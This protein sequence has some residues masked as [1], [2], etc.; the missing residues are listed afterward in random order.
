MNDINTTITELKKIVEDFIDERDWS[1]FHNPKNL[2]MALAIEAGELMDIFKWNST[3]E[4]DDMMS[5]KNTKQD[6]TDELADIMIYALAFSNR[7]NINISSAIEEK[8]IKNRKKYPTEK[9]K[10]HF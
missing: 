2:S 5:E 6:A 3:Q 1:Q 10:G 7:N 9:F 4:C 8:M